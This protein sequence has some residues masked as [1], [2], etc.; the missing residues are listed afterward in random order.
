MP[1]NISPYI[2]SFIKHA[3]EDNKTTETSF[4]DLQNTNFSSTSSFLYD[5]VGY[6]IKNTQQ[7]DVDWSKFENHTFFS[8]A[9]AK[10][11]LAFDQIINGY[12]FDGT[13]QEIEK[14]FE[15]LTGFEKWVFDNFPK[16]KGQLHFSG[17]LTGEDDD[18]TLGT[19]IKIKDQ[20]G[21]LYPDISSK[22]SGD[23]IIDPGGDK[24]FTIETHVFLPEQAN[25]NQVIFQKAS[26]SK[27]GISLYV[28][29]STSVTQA[30]VSFSVINDNKNITTFVTLEKGKFN[31]ICAT[32][33]R[34]SGVDYAEFFV[35]SELKQ[36]SKSKYQIGDMGISQSEILIGTG[37]TITIDGGNFVPAQTFSGSIDEFRIFHGIRTEK[38][39]K[40]FEK[41]AIYA[42]PELKLYYRF[43]EPPPPLTPISTDPVNS[44]VL[45]SSGNSLH[46][47]ITN[48]T[49]SLRQDASTDENSLMIYEKSETYPVLFPA[50]P[51]VVSLN[52]DLL[53]SASEYDKQ[54]PN[55]I[56]RLIPQHYFVEAEV[57][58]GVGINVDNESFTPYSGTGIPGQGKLNSSQIIASFLYIW[59]KFFDEIKISIDTFGNYGYVDYAG[60]DNM[61]KN[62]LFDLAKQNGFHIPPLF[63][64]S[65]IEQYV[66]AENIGE[67]IATSTYPLK[68][69]QNELLKRVL[70]N[71]PDILRSKGTQH[72][73]KSFLRSIGID[74]ENS[75]RIREYGGPTKRQLTYSREK[76]QDAGAM[77]QFTTSS[78]AITPFL[79]SSRIEIGY[80][81]PIGN[82][83]F[84]KQFPPHG[85]S[86]N[87]NDGLL[88][89][90]SWC[91]EAIYK[92]L[93][94]NLDFF[95][96]SDK[97]SLCRMFVTGS[98]GLSCVANLISIYSS[99]GSRIE[100][101]VRPGT[102]SNSPLF[103]LELPMPSMGLFDESRWN[104]SFGCTRNDSIGSRVSSSYYLRAGSQL[105][106]E[107]TWYQTT[108]SYFEETPY[109]E[110]NVFRTINATYNASGTYI[111]IGNNQSFNAGP[112]YKFLSD[113]VR[114][115]TT[116]RITSF[117]G[118]VSNLRFWSKSFSASEWKEHI[119][120]YKSLG[121]NNPYSNWNFVSN[122]TGSWERLRLDSLMKQEVRTANSDIAL[123]NLGT[124]KFLDFS[125]NNLHVSGTGFPIDKQTL[126]GEIFDHSYLSPYFDEASS[127]EKIR[128]RGYQD[129]DLVKEKPWAM[130]APV[131]EL[132]PSEKPSDD[133]RLSI[134]FSII[135]S[136]NKDIVTMF[137]TFETIE[138]ALGSPELVY[139]PDYPDLA[140]LREIYFNRISEKINFQGFFNF[141]RWFD[142]SI[143][144][145]I[146][147]LIPRKTKFKGTNFVIESHMLERNKLEYYS[148]EIY[149]GES[150]RNKIKDV[151]LLQQVVGNIKKY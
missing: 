27:H 47:L 104:I 6:P 4:S 30:N 75:L 138:S 46:A 13:R 65:S 125:L 35:N 101:Y 145:I 133:V 17:T 68:Y 32:L 143:G 109:A 67:E 57:Q 5:P 52:N 108:S 63:T 129:Y 45:D 24:S 100:L 74:P 25:D 64:N 7:L 118:K 50:Y 127:S 48:Y 86:D 112:S 119:L 40:L 3:L 111:A 9:E 20:A 61:P 56:T 80:P 37:T 34:S 102:N 106:G 92:Y 120:N 110:D 126:V 15:K 137:S 62:F 130:P 87:I 79:S 38:Q 116:S 36:K 117:N 70:I 113:S 43:N 44:I 96:D 23:P 121:V 103:K 58:D 128:I 1:V 54:N 150:D 107:M 85:V 140:K 26:D 93:P 147:Q 72:S 41:K 60:V 8:S 22:K 105:N 29:Q 131:N 18:G 84:K 135:D 88:T 49:G 99:S 10:V 19:W 97:Q 139:S 142:R 115:P 78:L 82:M 77:A 76:K 42:S 2:P 90:G 71:L 81:N 148:S 95:Q 141:F 69:I 73:I 124:I 21:F 39:Q 51:G 91:V 11:N 144:T 59:A 149:L 122:A 132:N 33:N 14:F 53:L 16:Y 31:H 134:E 146:D 151:L 89:S 136:L 123:G 98:D 28:S 55:L 94:K 66:D 12:P 114:S 83:V